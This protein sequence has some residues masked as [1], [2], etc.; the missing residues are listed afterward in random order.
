[1]S[2]KFGHLVIFKGFVFFFFF[3]LFLCLI[4]LVHIYLSKFVS[5]L[6][7][8]LVESDTD[9]KFIEVSFTGGLTPHE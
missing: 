9:L 2:P 6:S 5:T 4:S 7:T 3:S 1:M 8:A